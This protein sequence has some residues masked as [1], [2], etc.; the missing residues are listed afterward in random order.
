MTK[1]S[2]TESPS[3]AESLLVSRMPPVHL[4]VHVAGLENLDGWQVVRAHTSL[5]SGRAL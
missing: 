3:N 4:F 2:S 5:R 1:S